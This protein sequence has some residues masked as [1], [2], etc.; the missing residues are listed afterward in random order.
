M[1]KLRIQ[2]ANG[3]LLFQLTSFSWLLKN[4]GQFNASLAWNS[5]NTREIR[6]LSGLFLISL[7][8]T[9]SRQQ[10][11]VRLLAFNRISFLLLQNINTA[12]FRPSFSFSFCLVIAW[13]A[14]KAINHEHPGIFIRRPQLAMDVDMGLQLPARAPEYTCSWLQA[15]IWLFF[16]LISGFLMLST[17]VAAH[18]SCSLPT[19]T[20][21]LRL[22][23][24]N[25]Y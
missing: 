18:T 3:V 8:N 16:S 1:E 20:F 11:N 12:S 6:M 17:C 24:S 22:F 9:P 23:K 4:A 15:P 25:L 13:L 5:C 14:D 21:K 7:W 10:E 19:C 2:W